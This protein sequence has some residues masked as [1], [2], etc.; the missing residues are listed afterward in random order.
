MNMTRLLNEERK[1]LENIKA[2]AAHAAKAAQTARQTAVGAKKKLKQ[3]RKQA[4]VTKKI[5]RKAE[6]EAE[7]AL[8]ALDRA[9]TRLEKLERRA[10]KKERKQNASAKMPPKKKTAARN[11]VRSGMPKKAQAKIIRHGVKSKPQQNPRIHAAN[12]KKVDKIPVSPAL[13][14]EPVTSQTGLLEDAPASNPDAPVV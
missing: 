10:L 1:N 8:E 6:D 12:Q 11:Q 14:V 13:P 9:Q 4:K 5:A 2:Q 3:A 7:K